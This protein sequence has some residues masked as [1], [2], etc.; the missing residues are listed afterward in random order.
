M[1]LFLW[2]HVILSN[3]FIQSYF[4]V[5]IQLILITNLLFEKRVITT[6]VSVSYITN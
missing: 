3:S 1:L 2:W 4:S 5:D 6:N